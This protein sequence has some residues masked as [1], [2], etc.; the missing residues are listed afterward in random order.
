M[1]K[2]SMPHKVMPMPKEHKKSMPMPMPTKKG[3]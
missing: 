2:K 1:Q 3:K